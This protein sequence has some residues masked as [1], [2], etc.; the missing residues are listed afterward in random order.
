MLAENCEILYSLTLFH[1]FNQ[2]LLPL[3][4]NASTKG[5]SLGMEL[6]NAAGWAKKLE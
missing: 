4:F 3:V 6:D 1:Q 2:F 5:N